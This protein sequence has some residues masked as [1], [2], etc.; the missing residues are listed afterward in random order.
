M[1]DTPRSGD[2]LPEALPEARLERERRV[3]LVW[4]IP[5]VALL[6]AAWLGYRAYTQQG[7]LVTIGFE[8]AEGLEAGKTRVRYKDVDI[9][10]VEAIDLAPDL[11]RVLVRA[12]L[13]AA[14]SDYIN[15]KARFWVVRPRLT[16]GQVSGLATLVGGAYIAADLSA[17]DTPQRAFDGLE[18]PPVVTAVER[19]SVFILRADALGSLAAGSPVLYRGIEVGTVVGYTLRD[20][21]SVAIQAFVNAP[22]DAWV[23]ANTRFWNA[24]GIGLSLDASGIRVDTE[25]LASVLLGGIAFDD[26][27]NTPSD[28]RAQPETEFRL[29]ADRD[30]AMA[31]QYAQREDWQLLFAG[32]VRGLVVGAPVE[33]RGIRIGEVT[34]IKLRMDSEQRRVE[35]PVEIAIE[36]GRLGGSEDAATRRQLWDELVAQGLRAQLKN[37][38]L[39]TGALYVDLD[40]HPDDAPRSIVWDAGAPRLPTVPTALDQLSDLLGK[41]VRLPLDSMGSDLAA[42]LAAL[43]DTTEATNSLLERI[44]RETASELNQTL[45]QTRKTLVALEKVLATNSPLQSEALRIFKELGTAARSLRIMS[46]YLERHPEALLRGKEDPANENLCT[47]GSV[48]AGIVCGRLREHAAG[49]LLHARHG[50]GIDRRCGNAA[51]T[52]IGARSDRSAAIPRSAADRDA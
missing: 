48:D 41:L 19:G 27:P 17:G 50:I 23:N 35:I 45:V 26:L 30:A 11:A 12:R 25:S 29:F 22:H 46:D 28:A 34:G 18:T 43:R 3:S 47:S 31:P 52:V 7:P 44:D 33:F 15:D 36:S 1:P 2:D 49:P 21:R 6:A 20:D 37:G 16:R 9:G 42:T 40:F 13:A 39:L 24:S 14:L 10:V 5:L 51:P 38:N 32:S 8:T 4:L